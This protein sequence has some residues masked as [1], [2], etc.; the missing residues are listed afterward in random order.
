MY[1]LIE[2]KIDSG[3]GSLVLNR[4]EI[5]NAFN[6][7][8]ILEIITAFKVFSKD[9]SIRVVT[10]TGK[11]K[12]FCAGADLNWM[13]GMVSYS[14]E[15]NLKDSENLWQMFELINNFAKPVLGK[16][17]GHALG[18]GVGLLSVCDFALA[19]SKAKIGFTEVKLGIIPAVISPFVI[20]KIGRSFA[21]AWFL[22][23]DLFDANYGNH[24]GL[25]HKVCSPEELDQS[26]DE[27]VG[28]FL[29]AGPN[30]AIEAKKLIK[31]VSISK[32]LKRYTCGA[33][34]KMRISEEGQEGMTALLDKK[35]ASWIK[36]S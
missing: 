28:K 36:D 3:V 5:H 25:V 20:D 21:R 23:G 34:S 8:M 7:K 32:D 4:P 2:V 13:K 22:S 31:E 29:L 30:A 18:G 6:D 12:S 11:G 27:L 33:I 24:I 35:K 9:D 17:N 10:I 1:K 16:I 19:S 26:F 14:F 15:E